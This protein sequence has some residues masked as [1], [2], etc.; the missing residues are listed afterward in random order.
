MTDLDTLTAPIKEYLSG[1]QPVPDR[2]LL[3]MEL[4]AL[5]AQLE[6]K[7]LEPPTEEQKAKILEFKTE[8]AQDMSYREIAMTYMMPDTLLGFKDE[9]DWLDMTFHPKSL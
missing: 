6:D 9:L 8:I 2:L 1:D 3:A 5:A 7:G 4:R